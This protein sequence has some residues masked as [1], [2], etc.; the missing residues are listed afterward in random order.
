MNIL[1][2]LL[3]LTTWNAAFEATPAGTDDASQ[4]DDRIV[5]LKGATRE[6]LTKEHVM[7]LSSGLVASDGWHRSGSARVY[8]G[9]TNP[10]TKP[11]GV[12]ALDTNDTGR[13]FFNTSSS[14][15]YTYI[16]GTGWVLTGIEELPIGT[17]YIQFPSQTIPA[18]L[19]GGTWSNIS[20]SYAGLFFRAEG[21]HAAA[22][23]GGTQAGSTVAK[24]YSYGVASQSGLFDVLNYDTYSNST[25]SL[26]PFLFGSATSCD[27]FYYTIRPVNQTIRIW[28]RTA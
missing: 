23:E 28:K 16:Y 27:Y 11:D 22:F 8:T 14:K 5:E 24:K 26:V 25:A 6:R 2:Y 21:G 3:S 9:T 1:K 19:Y 7:D 12:T 13:Q 10:T 15:L 17:V 20:S 4:G 18:T